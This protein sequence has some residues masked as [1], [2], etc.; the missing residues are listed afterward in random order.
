MF[1]SPGEPE[2]DIV[3]LTSDSRA[4][5]PG[6]LFAALPGTNTDGARF[7]A[8][9]ARRGASAILAPPS[10]AALVHEANLPLIADENPRRR[11]ALMAARF[12][13]EQ[14]DTIAAVT[15]TNGKSSV[16]SFTRQVWQRLGRRA[17][18]MGTLGV[19]A[20]GFEAGPSLTTPDPADLHQALAALANDG[21]DRLAFEASSH[22]LAQYRSDGVRLSAAAFTNLTR[23][24][25]DYH[26]TEAAYFDAKARLFEEL[27]P[28]GGAAVL[29]ANSD[30]FGA[31]CEISRRRG[32]R[33]I[34]Y[35]SGD[36]DVA[37]V[38]RERQAGGQ[39]LEIVV[40]GQTHRVETG[41]AGD[42][43]AE[44]LLCALALTIGCG[45]NPASAVQALGGVAGVPGRLDLIAR[46]DDGA[47]IYVDYAHT[48]DALIAAL[49]AMRA[50]TDGRL[51]LVFGCGGDRD[52]GKR[53]QM[54]AIA[55]ELA[56]LVIVTD[57]NPR[58]EDPATIRAEILA[59][60]PDA[61]EIGDRAEAI[62]QAVRGL[63]AGDVLLIAGKGHETYQIIGADTIAFD[64][65][66]A[67][68]KALAALGDAA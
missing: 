16:V 11:Y 22:G 53:P 4:V 10:A 15:G 17:A 47:A 3:G 61:T 35:G 21:I 8:D 67:A 50:H 28:A 46:R 49:R 62:S 52:P 13:G 26:G 1:L 27:L 65:A 18:S 29:N 31:L 57:D 64:D 24:H 42:F 12:Y 7:I 44:N 45:E 51:H 54:G 30:R 40:D 39:R 66:D 14:P 68:R 60:C 33:I 2:I 38:A 48:P 56:D 36:C 23:D 59:A 20:P 41:L 5:K 43:Q 32:H 25:L 55:A 34:S 58:D 63:A 19:C 6:F 9:A 37:L